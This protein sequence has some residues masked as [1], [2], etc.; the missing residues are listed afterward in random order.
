MRHHIPKE[1]ASMFEQGL[2]NP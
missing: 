2:N 1:Q